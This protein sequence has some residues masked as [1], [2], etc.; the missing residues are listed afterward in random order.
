MAKLVFNSVSIR[1]PIFS[2]RN[3]SLRNQ[4]VRLATGGII[5]SESGET[6]VVSALKNVTF[7]LKNGDSVGLVGHNG[8]GK[9]TL[10]RTMAGVYHPTSGSIVREG[11]ISTLLELGAGMEPELNG[12]ENII[13]MGIY[14]GLS[15]EQAKALIP[16]IEVFTELG[17]FLDLP[18]RT[19]S[20]GMATRLMFAVA[21]SSKPDILLVD[22]IFGMGDA[23]FQIKAQAKM[24]SLINSVGIFVFASHN[25]ELLKKYCNRFFKLDHGELTEIDSQAI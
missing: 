20:S 23:S 2:S 4:I 25:H 5:E 6:Q 12:Y 19:Y 17:E 13:R 18:V 16:E 14:L 15:I 21:T 8:A 22:E 9:S 7:Q 24:E 10:L 3:K 11:N 1:Y